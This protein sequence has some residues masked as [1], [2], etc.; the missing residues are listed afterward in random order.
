MAQRD[1]VSDPDSRLF[2]LFL[3]QWHVSVAGSARAQA[4]VSEI[5]NKVIS[6]DD[7]VGVMTP[8][9]SPQ[10]M[11]VTRRVSAIERMLKDNWTWGERDKLNT[12][13]PRE[14]E[15]QICYPDDPGSPVMGVARELIER[16]RERK[17]LRALDALIGH[18]GTLREDRK[19]VVLLTEGWVLFRRN[20]RLGGVLTPGS[21]PGPPPVGVGPG[22]RIITGDDSRQNLSGL[23][24]C[25]RER[26]VLSFDER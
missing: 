23:D 16:R 1:A 22:G 13:D 24:S 2:V 11:N 4:P 9:M 12:S 6:P 7:L 21:I 20:D 14:R 10:N 26:V 5:L 19:F 25:D 18:L 17:T 3:D 15:L 8:E